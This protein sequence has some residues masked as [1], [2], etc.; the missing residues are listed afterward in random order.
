MLRDHLCT[1]AWDALQVAA[2]LAEQKQR[3]RTRGGGLR[4]ALPRRWLPRHKPWRPA[5][6]QG[7]H[8]HSL[9]EVLVMAE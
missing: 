4:R 2:D 6:P 8:D 5:A 7:K 1:T 9:Q 3:E